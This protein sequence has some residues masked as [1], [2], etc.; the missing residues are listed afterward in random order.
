M[1]VCLKVLYLK[2]MSC[3]IN[4]LFIYNFSI[5]ISKDLE[6]KRMILI[7]SSKKQIRNNL[8]ISISKHSTSFSI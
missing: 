2:G 7:K 1:A 5:R 3:Q 8:M 4:L 6:L